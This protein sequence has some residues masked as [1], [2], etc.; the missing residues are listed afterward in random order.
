MRK[1]CFQMFLLQIFYLEKIDS[2]SIIKNM[3]ENNLEINTFSILVKS[4]NLDESEYIKKAVTKYKTNH[5][6]YIVD[7]KFAMRLF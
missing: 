5:K 2:T 4:P 7:K 3:F 1:E 6:S